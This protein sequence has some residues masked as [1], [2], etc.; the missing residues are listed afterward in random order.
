MAKI[1]KIA[2]VLKLDKILFEFLKIPF[3]YMK[4]IIKK[5]D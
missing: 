5:N 2:M 1:A 4:L 3:P